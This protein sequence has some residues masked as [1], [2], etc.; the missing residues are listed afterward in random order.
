MSTKRIARGCLYEDFEVGQSFAHHWGKT[1]TAH[2][3]SW[4]ST[5]T[6]Q[7]NPLYHDQTYARE[8]GYESI[9]IHPLFV[10]TTALGLSVEDLTEAGGPFLGVDDLTFHRT[11]YAGDT[12]RAH[13]VVLERRTSASRPGWGIVEWR[14]SAENQ[15][16]EPVLEFRRRNLSK[17]RAAAALSTKEKA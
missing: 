1:F 2:D 10:F 6:M 13:S 12:I 3:G 16:G 11:V 5:M 15:T 9:P 17:M 4:Y 7:Y 14:T 8:L